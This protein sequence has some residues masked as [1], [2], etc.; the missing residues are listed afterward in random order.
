[1]Q[2]ANLYILF[3]YKCYGMILFDDIRSPGIGFRTSFVY[4]DLR[5]WSN[6]F[7]HRRL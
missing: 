1:M 5:R 2:D 7:I 4:F 6:N 3:K